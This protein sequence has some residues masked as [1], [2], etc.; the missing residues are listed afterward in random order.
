MTAKPASQNKIHPAGN[1][2]WN[3]KKTIALISVFFILLLIG[4]WI[5][6]K[7]TGDSDYIFDKS[8]NISLEDVK[9]ARRSLPRIETD[10]G[11]HP[12]SVA[13]DPEGHHALPPD[14]Q[15]L[16]LRQIF[17][18]GLINSYTTLKYFKHLEHMFRKSETLGEHLD[19]I[20]KY[21]FEQF[22]KE[23]AR[24]LF[25][26]YENYLH[27]EMDLIEEFQNLTSAKSTEEAIDI[28]K[29]IQAFR[30][31]RLGTDLADKLFGADVKAKEY[32][33]RR[34]DIVGD[35]TLYGAAKEKMLKKL[36]EEMWGEDALAIEEHPNDYNRYQEKLLIYEKDL[37][38]IG[39][40]EM[41]QA[42][43]KEFRTQF[44]APEVV[45]RLEDVDRHIAAEAQK[46][47]DYRDKEQKI[48]ENT[49]L[50][51]ATKSEKIQALRRDIFG[52]DA[53]AFSRRE[54]MRLELEKMI[55][56]N[57]KKE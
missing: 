28:L 6:P 30:R 29:Q 18:E 51:E 24:I 56:E 8:Y 39:S 13:A 47:S 55:Q 19:D 34:A 14:E 50:S 57:E 43:I 53:D 46:E 15:G 3:R 10:N 31:D 25:D 41:R 40:E 16:D 27:C 21:L 35:D 36:N 4:Y 1:P 26:T 42:K 32:A 7:D 12:A 9:K 45:A 11:R 2:F 33:F 23:E 38:D 54:T 5:F 20:R 52:D 22:S 37:A 44:F 17:G 49:G 48:L